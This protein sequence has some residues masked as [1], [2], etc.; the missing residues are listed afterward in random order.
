MIRVEQAKYSAALILPRI[1]GYAYP[2]QRITSNQAVTP[3]S[4]WLQSLRNAGLKGLDSGLRRNEGVQRD[5]ESKC[6]GRYKHDRIDCLHHRPL[7]PFHGY[8]S[9]IVAAA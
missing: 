9:L 4:A 1:Y 8:V 7:Q 3:A 2:V 5:G 6:S